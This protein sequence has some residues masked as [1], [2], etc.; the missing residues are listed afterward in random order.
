LLASI[1]DERKQQSL[2]NGGVFEKRKIGA[3]DDFLFIND[4]FAN[5]QDF[6]LDVLLGAPD[7]AEGGASVVDTIAVLDV[8]LIVKSARIRRT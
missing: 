8:P 5:H 1:D 6:V 2:A 3:R 7:L 4:S